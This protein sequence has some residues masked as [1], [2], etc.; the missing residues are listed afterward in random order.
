[1]K[2]P[3]N[4]KKNILFI[5]WVIFLSI[6]SIVQSI[7]YDY[8]HLS[9]I[10]D[11]EGFL[12][13]TVNTIFFQLITHFFRKLSFENR[14]IRIFAMISPALILTILLIPAPPF[15][16]IF[17]PIAIYNLIIGFIADQLRIFIEREK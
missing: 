16:V 11:Y 6:F 1:M 13:A 14:S 9:I 7:L 2:I 15:F 10:R 8:I 4:I 3:Q 5:S 17:I 12:V